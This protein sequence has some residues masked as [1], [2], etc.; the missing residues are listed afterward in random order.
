M[1]SDNAPDEGD[2]AAYLERREATAEPASVP[3]RSHEGPKVEKEH[4]P[5][6]QQRD[7]SIEDVVV[8]GEEPTEAFL[9]EFSALESA[10]VLSDEELAK[11]ALEHP[12]DDD[13]PSTPE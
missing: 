10:P 7:Q 9:E 13:D 2:F 1:P 8:H 3:P 5:S 6:S 4:D 11:Q 12:G